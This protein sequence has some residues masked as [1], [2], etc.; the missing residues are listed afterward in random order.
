MFSGNEAKKAAS[1]LPDSKVEVT[2]SKAMSG[3]SIILKPCACSLARAACHSASVNA[4]GRL[5]TVTILPHVHRDHMTPQLG[6]R[7]AACAAARS[8]RSRPAGRIRRDACR[9]SYQRDTDSI[10]PGF[11]AR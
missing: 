6:R 2:V 9:R 4:S 10:P 11:S 5:I 1:A 3:P 8:R 7:H